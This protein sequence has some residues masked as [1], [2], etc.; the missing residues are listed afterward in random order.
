MTKADLKR[1]IEYEKDVSKKYYCVIEEIITR[2]NEFDSLDE[3]LFYL[4]YS[5]ELIKS[6]MVSEY[7]ALSFYPYY[8]KATEKYKFCLNSGI[9]SFSQYNKTVSEINTAGKTIMTTTIKHRSIVEL[10]KSGKFEGVGKV[11]YNPQLNMIIAYGDG[12][13]RLAAIRYFEKKEPVSAIIIDFSKQYDAIV[14]NGILWKNTLDN[15]IELTSDYRFSVLYT[16]CALIKHL[17][18]NNHNCLSASM[19]GITIRKNL[20]IDYEPNK[21]KEITNNK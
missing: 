3:K 15:D 13:H 21:V 5:I 8:C 19:T 1:F 2:I 11:I 9:L 18:S 20:I 14:T 6:A 10:V 17:E 12:Y 4:N 16:L 7:A